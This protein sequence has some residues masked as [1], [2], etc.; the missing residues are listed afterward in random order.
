ML[1]KFV[2]VLA[3]P[4]ANGQAFPS[5][6]HTQ[7]NGQV[8]RTNR[9]LK[10]GIKSRLGTKHT[11][12]VDELPHVLWAYRTQKKTSNSETPFS[13]SEAMIPEEIG[14]PSARI[15]SITDNDTE[16]CLNLDLLEERREW[17]LIRESNYKR[18]F[19]KYYDSCVKICQFQA[20]DY[21]FRNNEASC[22]EPPGKLAPTWEG[23]YN[24][25]GVLD[26]GTLM[27]GQFVY[28]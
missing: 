11:G 22:Q 20:G 3:H 14:I 1:E 10:D 18:Q 24:I 5:V 8:E 15:L 28:V 6:A 23:P 19:Q 2:L 25:K 27:V 7:A 12:W 21:L 16:L 13:L 4:Q 9:S 17:E 26:K